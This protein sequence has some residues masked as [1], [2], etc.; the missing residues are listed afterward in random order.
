M[1]EEKTAGLEPARFLS[2]PLAGAE[3]L[4]CSEKREEGEVDE[5]KEEITVSFL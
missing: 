2:V 4:W 3:L 1:V 5:K